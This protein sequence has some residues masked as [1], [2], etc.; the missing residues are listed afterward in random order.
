MARRFEVSTVF[1]GIDRMSAPISRIQSR[2]TSM[3]RSVD[4]QL[5]RMTRATDRLVGG[6]KR[7]GRA[8]LVV[9]TVAAAGLAQAAAAGIDFEQTMVNATTKMG[10]G[11]R[12]G[13]E[14]FEQ[15]NAAARQV[16]ATTE[17]TATQSAEALNFLAMAGFNAEQSIAALPQVVDLATSAQLD[18]AQATSIAADSLGVFGLTSKDA[19][20]QA[21]NLTRVNDVLAKTA[22]SANTDIAQ[23][24]EAMR[25]GG[26]IATTLG[27][28]METVAAMIGTMAAAGVK[29]DVAGTAVANSFLNLVT[30]VGEAAKVTRRLGLNFKDAQGNLK[31]MPDVIDELNRKTKD[32]TKTQRTAAIAAIFG[33]EGLAGITKVVLEGGEALR[34]FREELRN[35]TGASRE[36]AKEQRDTTRGSLNALKATIQEVSIALFDT[37]KGPLRDA[38]DMTT[39]WV[40]TNGQL[41]GQDIGQFILDVAANFS[42]YVE[43]GKQIAIVV[44]ALWGLNLALKAIA[45]TTAALNGLLAINPFVLLGTALAG[46]ILFTEELIGLFEELPQVAQLLL[47]PFNA[48]LRT[49]QFLKEGILEAVSLAGQ[50][51]STLGFGDD[52]TPDI[53]VG[54]GAARGD[55]VPA[56]SSP[57]ER[58][59]R[60]ISETI[61]SSSNEVIIK[62]ETGRA[63]I[64]NIMG[65]QTL[66]VAQTGGF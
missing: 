55:G 3:T 63:E 56:I 12:R 66:T 11:A 25:K 36:M 38:I 37:T 54:G 61:E 14:A 64:Q 28:D 15:L 21:K 52:I 22:S 49:V 19:I 43:R 40:R 59:A 60:S 53:I 30:P 6:L 23:L 34:V 33:R 50:L 46:L 45:V 57:Q 16:G 2:L 58:T 1:R 7:V 39:E 29:A 5:R 17:F 48:I 47:G 18:L 4:R 13:T 62:D 44:G 20:Q 24:F 51:G 32:L 41:I 31:D 65:P 42:T 10:E 27:V 26:P 9:G 8:A 35:A